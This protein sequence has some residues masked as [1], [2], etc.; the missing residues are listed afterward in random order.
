LNALPYHPVW[1]CAALTDC[2]PHFRS[3]DGSE[4][5]VQIFAVR[6]TRRIVAY[7]TKEDRYDTD[8]PDILK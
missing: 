2:I 1:N 5:S 8:V 6:I 4:V 7:C 3:T